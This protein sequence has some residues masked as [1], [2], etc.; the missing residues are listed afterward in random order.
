MTSCLPPSSQVSLAGGVV[1]RG[2]SPCQ[3]PVSFATMGLDSGL[4]W[5]SGTGGGA[6]EASWGGAVDLGGSAGPW[7]PGKPPRESL[8]SASDAPDASSFSL[9]QRGLCVML[10]NTQL[11]LS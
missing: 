10:V 5:C 9:W 2:A 3:G 8:A 7:G 4:V 1:G 6:W 11:I